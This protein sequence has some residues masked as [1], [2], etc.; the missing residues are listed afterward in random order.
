MRDQET[1]EILTV[2]E[3][4]KNVFL[5]KKFETIDIKNT[6]KLFS[7]TLSEEIKFCV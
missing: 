3:K 4:L 2:N 5:I 7:L 1:H 6:S